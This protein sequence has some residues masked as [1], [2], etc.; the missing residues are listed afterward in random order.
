MTTANTTTPRPADGAV[1]ALGV[2]SLCPLCGWQG[3]QDVELRWATK[4]N[5]C[6]LPDHGKVDWK[7]P[8]CGAWVTPEDEDEDLE[9]F[10]DEPHF[11]HAKTCPSYCDYACNQHGFEHAEAI[12]HRRHNA[13]LRRGE[14]VASKNSLGSN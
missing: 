6:G 14:A 3:K 11:L 4:P 1:P 10:E 8:G 5:T 2:H 9:T 7:C 13:A 12:K